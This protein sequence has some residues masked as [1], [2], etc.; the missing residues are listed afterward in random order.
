MNSTTNAN[1]TKSSGAKQLWL[2][3]D[4]PGGKQTPYLQV[5]V[6]NMLGVQVVDAIQDLFEKLGGLLLTERLLLSQ[7]VEELSTCH[8]ENT[9]KTLVKGFL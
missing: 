5:E 7:E 9:G 2:I 4:R 3:H 8:T 6:G 1:I